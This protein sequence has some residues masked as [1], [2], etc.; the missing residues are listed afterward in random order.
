MMRTTFPRTA[1]ALVA[2]VALLAACSTSGE[3][4]PVDSGTTTSTG[5]NGDAGD[6]GGDA[7]SLAGDV[8][9]WMYP[10]VADEPTHQAFWDAQ[11][12][13][14]KAEEPD[15][16]VN[17]EIYP[18]A[19]RD[20]AI[21]AALASNTAPDAIYLVPDQVS[22]YANALAP[23]DDLFSDE[24]WNDVLPN[25]KDA[26]TIDGNVMSAP[27]LTSS[28]PLVCNREVFEAIGETTYPQTWD[29][30]LALGPKLAEQ[31]MYLTTYM[32]SV[33]QTLNMTFYPL[34]W[35]A[36]GNVFSDDFSEVTF[37]DEA[38]VEALTFLKT[39]VDNNWVEPDALTTTPAT[40]QLALANGRVACNWIL[41][42]QDIVAAWGE[43]NVEVVGSL[44]KEQ[45]ML[46]GTIGSISVFEQ[47]ENKE[48]AA[49]FAEHVLTGDS[50]IEYLETSQ[51]FSPL[52]S[53]PPL[54]ADDPVVGLV[55]E[56]VPLTFVGQ[57]HPEARAIM[58]VLAPEIQAVLVSGDDPAAALNRAA[59]ESAYILGQ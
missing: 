16:N 58:G 41:P 15:V 5:D 53:T 35:Q 56:T 39:M 50:L 49:A 37:N 46:Y 17:V 30:F 27:L 1:V 42:V 31:D 9:I 22:T 59:E 33:E 29:E 20:E 3:S 25:V 47:S 13:S 55:E 11:I 14:F 8:T 48:A 34:V 2:G 7:G 36:G 40:E 26:L 52:Q 28:N 12:E 44:S 54:F 19:N 4:D 10:V 6:T 32:G 43:E 18:W 21:S 51:F 23:L 38:G 24:Y 57:L 45:P